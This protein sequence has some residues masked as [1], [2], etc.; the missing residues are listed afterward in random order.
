[1]AAVPERWLSVEE[2]ARHLGVSKES[3]YRW[4]ESAKIPAH[5]VGRQWR[6]QAA[7]VD[8]WVVSGKALDQSNDGSTPGQATHVK[9]I[10]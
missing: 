4:V 2:I 5:K 9:E 1:M 7:E 3:I 8:A 6:F 10:L